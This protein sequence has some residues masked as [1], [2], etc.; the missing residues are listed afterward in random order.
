MAHTIGCCGNIDY[1]TVAD[2]RKVMQVEAGS[3]F[4]CPECAKPLRSP[5]GRAPG[6]L[7]PALASIGV[8]VATGA[9]VYTGLI[10]GEAA[11]ASMM[12]AVSPAHTAVA[13]RQSAGFGAAPR[14]VTA[15]YV[16]ASPAETHTTTTTVSAARPIY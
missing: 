14:A 12:G 5:P 8:M 15:T 10:H 1:C 3:A 9:G 2:E 16:V 6:I 4:V 13:H 7:L 11:Y